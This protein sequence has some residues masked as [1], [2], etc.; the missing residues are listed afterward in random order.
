VE[1]WFGKPAV[2][3][4]DFIFVL[5]FHKAEFLFFIEYFPENIEF[6]PSYGGKQVRKSNR[7]SVFLFWPLFSRSEKQSDWFS[8]GIS[9]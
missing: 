1:V 9:P 4:A 5:F 8:D 7:P 2:L 6:P 3:T